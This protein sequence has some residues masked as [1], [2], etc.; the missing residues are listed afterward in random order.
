MARNPPPKNPEIQK[1]IFLGNLKSPKKSGS[2]DTSGSPVALFVPDIRPE[3]PKNTEIQKYS[4]L[5][6]QKLFFF[7]NLKNPKKSGRF[8]T[9]ESKRNTCTEIQ[10]SGH[11]PIKFQLAVLKKNQ[12]F[13]SSSLHE[14]HVLFT[15]ATPVEAIA[16]SISFLLS[17]SFNG[18]RAWALDS[19]IIHHHQHHQSP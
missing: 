1:F 11:R 6:I 7:G 14:Q 3:I 16:L 12:F 10:K 9:R 2:F 15:F 5:D 13:L 8:D 17:A 18:V 4:H 19:L